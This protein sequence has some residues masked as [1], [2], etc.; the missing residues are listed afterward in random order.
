M[1]PI[2]VAFLLILGA[3]GASGAEQAKPPHPAIWK[4]QGRNSTLYLLG[5]V[6]LL[7][8]NAAWRDARIDSAIDAADTFYFE[9][10]LEMDATKRF[11]AAEGSLPPGQSLRASLPPDFQRELDEDLASLAIPEANVDGRRP[12]LAM[13]LMLGLQ[14]RQA[15]L[16]STGVDVALMAEANARGKPLRYFETP[17]QQLALFALDDPK[18]ELENFESFLQDFKG[19]TA[20]IAP[21]MNAW[22]AGDQKK[23]E[24]MLMKDYA[25]H[26]ALRKAMFDD[27]N[28][29]WATTLKD[30][31]DTQSGT[32]LITVGAGHL[33]GEGG[34]PALLRRAG[35][36]VTEL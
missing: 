21:M 15:G 11:I 19:E 1:K 10:P 18:L 3:A 8:A 29:A 7:S 27:R 22:A 30:V 2:L 12:W 5:S 28:R 32:F 4:V 9:A 25:Q 24:A 13:V 35:Y 36:R 34:V 23:L 6:H 16:S 26:P 17:E 20:D 31:L 14:F 33:V